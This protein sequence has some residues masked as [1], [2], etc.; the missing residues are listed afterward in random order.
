MPN[1]TGRNQYSKGSKSLSSHG[2]SSQDSAASKARTKA[3]TKRAQA[4]KKK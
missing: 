2:K 4:R 1:P 3:A